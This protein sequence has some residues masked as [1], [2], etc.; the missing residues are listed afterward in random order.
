MP[1]GA[2]CDFGGSSF[3]MVVDPATGGRLDMATLDVDGN[4]SLN[5]SEKALSAGVTVYASGVQSAIGIVPT[6]TIVTAPAGA[7]SAARENLRHDRSDGCH[8]AGL[9]R[10][11]AIGGGYTGDLQLHAARPRRFQ[12]PRELAR[13]HELNCGGFHP[14]PGWISGADGGR[15]SRPPGY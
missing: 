11:Y 1:S 10:A 5:S 4:G 13:D 9:L 14:S 6:P 15:V 2:V 3:M 12:R 8:G 7:V